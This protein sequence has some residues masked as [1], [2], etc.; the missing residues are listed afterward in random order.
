MRTTILLFGLVLIAVLAG[1]VRAAG[2][3]D[4]ARFSARVDNPWFPLKPGTR[5]I[6]SGVKEGRAARDVVTVAHGTKTIAGVP[7]AVV[8]DR[9]YRA[10]RLVERTSD[11]YSQDREG[12]V[13]Y[14]GEATAELDRHGR[15]TSTEGSWK[16]G[17]HGA[18]AGIFMPAHP[19]VGRSYV[20]ELYRGHAEDHAQIIGLFDAV[21]G[22]RAKHALL[23]KEW[24]PLEPGIVGHKLYVRGIG[25]VLERSVSGENETLEL[26]SLRGA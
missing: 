14:F 22:P 8:E 6:Y 10:G 13:W 24:T 23:T 5:Y 19:R 9:L 4:P 7:C 12:N 16:D 17:V 26:V 3:L 18:R 1:D 25:Q 11:W 2:N 21:F 20:Q 15:V